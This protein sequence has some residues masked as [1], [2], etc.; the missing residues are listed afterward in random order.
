MAAINFVSIN[1]EA[2]TDTTCIDC[3]LYRNTRR[4]P[5][6]P[7]EQ[8]KVDVSQL[9]Y[10]NTYALSLISLII[11]SCA[12]DVQTLLDFVKICR[13]CAA[14]L[15]SAQFKRSWE[16]AVKHEFWQYPEL[17]IRSWIQQP[18][19]GLFDFTGPVSILHNLPVHR[20]LRGRG[21][22]NSS[23]KMTAWCVSGAPRGETISSRH[24]HH[25]ILSSSKR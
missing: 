25:L 11:K 21:S 6:L 5:A 18:V 3:R 19:G 1:V 7:K 14:M 12:V 13:S 22:D 16:S 9:Q 10:P 24:T 2:N 8:G 23:D 15:G 17:D 4:R 20:K